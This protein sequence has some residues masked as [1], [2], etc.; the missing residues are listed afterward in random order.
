MSIT[1]EKVAVLGAGTM[2]AQLAGH[3]ANAGIPA[4]LY[5]LNEELVSKGRENLT[6][7]KPAP[8]YNPKNVDLVEGCTYDKD[9]ER[10]GEVDWVVEAVAEN[11]EIKH[12]VYKQVAQHVKDDILLS[13]NSSGLPVV[14]IAKALPELSLIHI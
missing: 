11:L 1:I 10:L 8:L 3:V 14:Q 6:K 7:L 5:D 13:S 12:T 2:G 9:L 4:L